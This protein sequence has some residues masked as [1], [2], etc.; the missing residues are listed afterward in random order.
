MHA[1]IWPT[2]KVWHFSRHPQPCVS[3]LIRNRFW[4]DHCPDIHPYLRR[5]G[6][7]SVDSFRYWIDWNRRILEVPEPRRVTFRIE[8]IGESVLKRLAATI[9]TPCSTPFAAAKWEEKQR[10][11]PIPAAVEDEL[12]PLMA[13]LGYEPT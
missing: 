11:H 12:L 6:D 10:F 2:A 7:E 3:S 8:D 13:T 4:L 9:D 1:E 5:S